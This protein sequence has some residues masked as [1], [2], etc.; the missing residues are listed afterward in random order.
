MDLCHHLGVPLA[1]EKVEGPST[2]LVFLGNVI[3]SVAG[4]PRLPLEKLSRLR[5]LIQQWLGKKMCKKSELLSVAVCSDSRQISQTV[6]VAKCELLTNNTK[7][8]LCKSHRQH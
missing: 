2:S 8:D 4:E 7:C 1:E 5:L 3:D 6:R